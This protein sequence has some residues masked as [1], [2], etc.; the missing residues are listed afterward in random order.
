MDSPEEA[1]RYDMIFVISLRTVE[2]ACRLVIQSSNLGSTV[3]ATVNDAFGAASRS[4]AL[5]LTVA[6][7]DAR[8]EVGRGGE[9][10]PL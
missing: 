1:I 3:L 4:L 6:A 9:T 8:A 2:V 5:S 7:R 10:A